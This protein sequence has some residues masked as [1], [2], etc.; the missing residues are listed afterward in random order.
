MRMTT[1]TKLLASLPLGLAAAAL[2][3]SAAA[4]E[5][6]IDAER[7]KP[8]VTYDGFVTAEGSAVRPTA[9]RWAF[10]LALNYAFNP[11]VA[12]DQDG[13]ITTRFV[14]GRLGADLMASLT[15]AGP[16]AIGLDLPFFLVQTG[17]R[18]PS[19]A[20]LGDLRLVPKLRIL[21]DRESIG[22]AFALEVRAPTHAGDFA[23][24]TRVPVVWP[25]IIVDHR[26]GMGLRFG[27]NAGVLLREGTRF[28]NIDAAS[29]ITYAVALGYRF[30]G[31]DGMVELGGEA[32]GGVGL[33]AADLEEVP[34]EGLGYVKINPTDEW[35]IQ[36][37]PGVGLIPGYGIPTFRAF[38]A[39][40]YTPT[41]HDKDHDGVA[42][43]EDRCPDVPEDRDADQDSDGCPEED[44]DDDKD[45]VPNADDD[46]PDLKET[47]NGITDEDGCPDTGDRR[48]I[49][50][51]GQV[52]ILDNVRFKTGSAQ[53]D[54]ESYSL[55]DQVALTLK[56]NSQIK[57]IRVEGH[58]D[59]TGGR[60]MN[61]RLSKARAQ[62][63]K[64]Y[65][66][67]KGVSAD[68]LT[69]EGY[70]PDKPLVSGSDEAARAKNRRVEF[71]IDE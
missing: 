66:I 6:S 4:Q 59:D 34:L 19:F 27:V 15:V 62:S 47:I 12:V 64:Q 23:G 48:V 63:V 1:L 65:L 71:V 46:C 51:D 57:R 49:Y 32:N 25:K 3:P 33:A 11:L 20:G 56:A 26:F 45:G 18:D 29:E 17:D 52:R 44:A 67:K 58:S 14:G 54:P 21:D 38:A 35:E 39:V 7:F 16:F 10:G 70:G 43:D 9:D 53:I 37:G 60:E 13:D 31:N 68:R 42:D 69:S 5:T 8:A 41:T 2:A 40:R 24:G 61:I 50:E 36:A 30:G 22:L 55:L 28:A